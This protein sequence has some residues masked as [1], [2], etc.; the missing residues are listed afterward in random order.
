MQTYFPAGHTNSTCWAHRGAKNSSTD[1]LW[2]LWTLWT[3]RRLPVWVP[4]RW[5]GL[6]RPRR[7]LTALLSS[8][9]WWCLGVWGGTKTFWSPLQ[10]HRSYLLILYFIFETRMWGM[11]RPGVLEVALLRV[12]G[13]FRVFRRPLLGRGSCVTT[14]QHVGFRGAHLLHVYC[15]YALEPLGGALARVWLVF[16]QWL[17]LFVW[18]TSWVSRWW[19]AAVLVHHAHVIT[20]HRKKQAGLMEVML[21]VQRATMC[22]CH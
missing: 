1:G 19:I 14:K 2:T 20:F 4:V 10:L 15:I 11:K 16:E 22:M 17:S 9:R 7:R 5:T 18:R 3:L 12:L 13:R 21:V 6:C 8:D